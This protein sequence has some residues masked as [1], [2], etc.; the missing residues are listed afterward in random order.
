MTSGQAVTPGSQQGARRSDE[1]VMDVL[2]VEKNSLGVFKQFSS[3]S[4]EVVMAMSL[5]TCLPNV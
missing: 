4:T 1:L 5:V 2:N 3:F